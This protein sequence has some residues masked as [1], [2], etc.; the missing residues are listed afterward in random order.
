MTLGTAS[1]SSPLVEGPHDPD[2]PTFGFRT[3]VWAASPAVVGHHATRD[4]ESHYR[5]LANADSYR[6]H[7]TKMTWSRYV[8]LGYY[9]FDDCTVF[10]KHWAT[11]S[12]NTIFCHCVIWFNFM[13]HDVRR[14]QTQHPSNPPGM[15]NRHFSTL[16]A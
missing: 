12:T 13:Y 2:N 11:F 16:P 9:V 7:G 4:L 6:Q 1:P 10:D 3:D 14:P 8:S 5:R 15:G